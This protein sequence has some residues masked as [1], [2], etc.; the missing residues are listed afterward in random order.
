MLPEEATETDNRDEIYR[1]RFDKAQR[2]FL[3]RLVS[4]T[5]I[6]EHRTR[7]LGQHS[8]A[9]ERLLIYFRGQTQVDKYAIMVLEDFK[10][11]RIVGLS[12]RRGTPPRVVEDRIYPTADEAYHALFLRRIQDLM[13]S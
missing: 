12:G 5:V 4:D 10:A 11:Y 7:P 2:D 9:L 3:K 6:E 8:E 1:R 13:E